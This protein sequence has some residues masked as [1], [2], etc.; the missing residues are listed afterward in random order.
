MLLLLLY[1]NTGAQIFY[2]FYHLIHALEHKLPAPAILRGKSYC[3]GRRAELFC[4]CV[5]HLRPLA[6]CYFIRFFAGFVIFLAKQ[7][8]SAS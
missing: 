3:S 5:R 2:I 8:V 1:V 6:L 4:R 7:F